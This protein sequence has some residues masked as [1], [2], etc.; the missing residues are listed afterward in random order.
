MITMFIASGILFIIALIYL[1]FQEHKH[2]EQ[3]K[4][5]D[6]GLHNFALKGLK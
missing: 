3:M 6:Q 1:G 2:I 5:I 4:K